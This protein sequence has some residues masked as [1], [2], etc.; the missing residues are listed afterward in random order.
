MPP[1]YVVC[2]RWRLT[3]T[4]KQ[5]GYCTFD[6]EF[7]E[8]GLQPFQYTT[9]AYT[10]VQSAVDN[11]RAQL[12]APGQMWGIPDIGEMLIPGVTGGSF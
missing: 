11:L 5:G 10:A 6:I 3:E 9:D 4:Q 2:Q 1:L 8:Y 7:L 12:V